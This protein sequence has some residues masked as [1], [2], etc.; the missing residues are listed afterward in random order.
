MFLA[1][2]QTGSV[3]AC[4]Q[5]VIFYYRLNHMFINQLSIDFYFYL[6]LLAPFM[7]SILM[8]SNHYLITHFY[9]KFQ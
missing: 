6:T 4:V 5:C 8:H 7:L 1:T 3:Q 9:R 2:K